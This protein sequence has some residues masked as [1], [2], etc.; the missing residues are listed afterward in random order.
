MEKGL[1]NLKT[2]LSQRTTSFPEEDVIMFIT[3]MI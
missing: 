2:F 3:S 1:A